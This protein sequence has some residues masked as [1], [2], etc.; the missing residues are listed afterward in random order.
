MSAREE[1]RDLHQLHCCRGMFV[2]VK[3]GVFLPY[4][5]V[6]AVEALQSLDWKNEYH[7]V[8]SAVV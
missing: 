7:S 5:R 8:Q 1:L 4:W 6:E 2:I 3:Y